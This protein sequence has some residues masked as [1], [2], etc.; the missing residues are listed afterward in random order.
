M[1]PTQRE[2]VSAALAN[3][4]V[5]TWIW[6]AGSPEHLLL[7]GA[8][9][10]LP[11]DLSRIIPSEDWS[12]L[13]SRF[14]AALRKGCPFEASVTLRL[15][16]NAQCDVVFR[17][18]CRATAGTRKS[19]VSGVC[20]QRFD[21]GETTEQ[22]QWA[23]LAKLSHE[24]RSPLTAI[25]HL[26]AD[27]QGRNPP[28]ELS[29]V[30]VEIKSNGGFMLRL[31]EDMLDA[32]RSGEPESGGE[33]EIISSALLIEQLEPLANERAAIKGIG[34]GMHTDAEFPPCFWSEPV[35]LRR[36]LQNLIDNAIKFTQQGDVSV[37]LSRT[38]KGAA[39]QLHFDVADTGP[40]IPDEEIRRIFAPFE[41]GQT[42]LRNEQ[43]LGLGLA[44]S[45]QLA[46]VID[47]RLE[48]D[49]EP[50][51]GSRF[52]LSVPFKPVSASELRA[53]EMTAAAESAAV[54]SKRT[55]L[56]VEDHPLLS[57][58]T[59]RELTKLGC[60]VDIAANAQEALALVQEGER[61]IVILDLDLPDMSGYDLCRLLVE[62]DLAG[63]CRYVAYSG[64]DDTA[65]RQAA[66]AAGFDAFF[67]KPTSARDLL[68]P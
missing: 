68:G 29:D 47:G 37:E 28:P 49:S 21:A 48:I 2:E 20:W 24:L 4:G 65:D 25:M 8:R 26:A 53:M 66:E 41:Q 30:I 18:G 38:G 58:H 1:K 60:H 9:G 19:Q 5:C 12:F 35:A 13:Q 32:F 62:R 67:V 14:R 6:D 52:R 40:G 10:D 33:P 57:K 11:A 31:I 17:G 59:G 51:R 63:K 34:F 39:T 27:M 44:L 55:V 42:G 15:E 22:A 36:I 23:P 61:D 16:H 64:S 45:R 7:E 43:G 54:E 56:L 3:A 50:D 46:H